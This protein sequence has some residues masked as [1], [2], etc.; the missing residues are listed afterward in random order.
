MSKKLKLIEIRN[1]LPKK[2]QE[3]AITR[4][5]GEV[6]RVSTSEPAFARELQ[7]RGYI[8]IET[9]GTAS[10]SLDFEVCDRCLTVRSRGAV[11]NPHQ[12]AN[13]PN[14]S[15]IAEGMTQE[16]SKVGAKPAADR[17]IDDVD[18]SSPTP[19]AGEPELAPKSP[20]GGEAT[21]DG[22]EASTMAK[23]SRSAGDSS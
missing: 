22:F 15:T 19:R 7:R 20:K 8:P 12:A 14:G 17:A 11:E 13:L 1:P 10:G 5:R 9:D 23:T 4:L 6:W 2:E 16:A 3:T 18:D 21:N